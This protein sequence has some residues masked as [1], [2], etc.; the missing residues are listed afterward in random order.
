VNLKHATLIEV[1]KGQVLL[2]SVI[3]CGDAIFLGDENIYG[4]V[5]FERVSH[6]VYDR[7]SK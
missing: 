3:G 1:A 4:K 6:K 7:Q 5:E 2:V